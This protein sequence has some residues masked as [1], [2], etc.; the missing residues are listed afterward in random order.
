MA[1]V[2]D[3]RGSISCSLALRVRRERSSVREVSVLALFVSS[4]ASSVREVVLRL[5][6]RGSEGRASSAPPFR[7]T[8]VLGGP[9]LVE[10]ST[11]CLVEVDEF[12]CSFLGDSLG[13][14]RTSAFQSYLAIYR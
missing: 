10:D 2:A 13:F 5:A 11:T 3:L 12:S 6:L 7:F 14:L 1:V 4:R 8:V 9:C